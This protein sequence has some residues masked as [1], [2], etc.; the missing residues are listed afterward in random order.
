MAE[1]PQTELDKALAHV[2]DNP[3]EVHVFYNTFL[4]S[5]LYL[6]THDAPEGQEDDQKQLRP[7]FSQS[8]DTLFLMLFDSLERLKGWAQ[9]DMGYVG[10]QGH[11]I[12]DMMDPRFHWFLNYGSAYGHEFGSD[13]IKW[14]KSAVQQATQQPVTSEPGTA[15]I[16]A[17]TGVPDGLIEVLKAVAEKHETVRE[18]A[19]GHFLM[20]D[21]MA[22]PDLALAIRPEPLEE[23]LG[24]E[25]LNEFA[26]AARTILNEA[27]EFWVFEAGQTEFAER[28]L[29]TVPPFYSS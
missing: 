20:P 17:P 16:T 14:L 24:E 27:D 10:L 19:L 25:I 1:T 26:T 28:L 9:K 13:E 22:Q 15:E 18:V 4:N 2:Q 5:V 29:S 12:L 3:D 11:A 6:P 21:K 7:I 23:S 8:G